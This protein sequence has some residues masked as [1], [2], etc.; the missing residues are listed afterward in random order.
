[1][2]IEQS[3]FIEILNI[4]PLNSVCYLQAPNL[5][6]STLLKKIEDTDYPYYKSIK[7][8]RVNKELIIDSIL[9]E[10]IQDDIQSIQIRFDG[11]LL[12]EGFDGVECGTISKN[13]DLPSDFVEK[14]VNDD[15]CNISNNW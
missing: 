13:I 11:V 8:N 4:M 1:M 5:E 14:Y 15:F 10:D 3:F 2:T 7:I 9:N 12:F 6:S